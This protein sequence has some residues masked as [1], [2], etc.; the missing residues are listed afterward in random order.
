MPLRPFAALAL[1]A[2]LFLPRHVEAGWTDLGGMARP[3]REG[4]S[5]VFKNARGVAAVTVLG[6]QAVRVR[7]SPTPAFG[8]DHSYAVVSRDLG[9][10]EATF[11]VGDAQST[12]TTSALKVVVRHDP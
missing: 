3:A 8:R 9:S 7:F 4:A 1:S 11:D 2:V 12:I 6:P 5:L 10:T